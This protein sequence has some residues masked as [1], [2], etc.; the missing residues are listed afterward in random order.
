M[1]VLFPAQLRCPIPRTN[2][3]THLYAT[4]PA[5]C[6]SLPSLLTHTA[7]TL[8]S[9]LDSLDFGRPFFYRTSTINYQQLISFYLHPPT[10]FYIHLPRIFTRYPLPPSRCV[11]P[12]LPLSSLVPLWPIAP[13]MSPMLLP[14]HRVLPA[15]P[16]A[17]RA[18]PWSPPPLTPSS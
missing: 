3:P 12:L 13:P 5:V 1:L 4:P 11:S 6:P 17:Q 10:H 9:V 18:L 14:S 2:F 8:H 7:S 15:S 16:T